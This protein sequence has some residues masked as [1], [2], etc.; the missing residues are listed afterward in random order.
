MKTK[1]FNKLPSFWGRFFA[2]AVVALVATKAIYFYFMEAIEDCFISFFGMFSLAVPQIHISWPGDNQMA[3]LIGIVF[4]LVAIEFAYKDYSK[5]HNGVWKGAKP[6]RNNVYGSARLLTKPSD[7][8]RAFKTWKKGTKPDPGIVVG[9]IG[10]S[11]NKLLINSARHHNLV[12]G[13]TGSGKSTSV[14]LPSLIQL[15]DS[16]SNFVALDPKGE[17]YA[18]TGKHAVEH[19]ANVIVIDFSDPQTSDGWLPLQP[20]ID[21]AQG[22]NGRRKEELPGEIRIL[23]DTLIPE[24][25]ENSPIWTQAS[26]ILFSGLCAFVIESDSIPDE[27]KNLST[28]AALAFMPQEKLQE[29]VENLD[30]NSSAYLSLSSIAYAP[31]ETYGGFAVNLSTALSVYSDSFVSPLLAR[32][33]FQVEDFLNKQTCLYIRFN[34]ST[35]AFNPLIAAFVEQMIDA[36]RRMA[37]NRCGG[38]LSRSVY[39]ILEELPQLPKIS[40]GKTL[41]ICRSQGIYVTVCIQSRSMLEAVYKRDSAGIFNNLST[42]IILQSED[43]DTNKYYSELFGNYTV[44][45]V[46]QSQTSSN[47]SGSNTKSYSFHKAQLFP[48]DDLAEWGYETGHLVMKNGRLY[49]CSSLP[50]SKTFVGDMLGLHGVE[51]GDLNLGDIAP[52]RPV[53]NPDPAPSKSWSDLDFASESRAIAQ[54]I[55]SM[56]VDP[57]YC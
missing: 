8:K 50:I 47:N 32:S 48:P 42:T 49:A 6:S 26:R 28:V 25:S 22:L 23:A 7:L 37:E 46:S 31:A 16:D 56:N 39:F 54:A 17:L 13:G 55:D 14:L 9:G 41:A 29:I 40:L 51:P 36:L 24:R 53:K 2:Y 27:C 11:K 34:S 35:E 52:L 30:E 21:C 33:D 12:L 57:R 4:L 10:S 20:A 3:L 5:F 15:I 45:V 1:S 38:K 43:L 19:G 44:E 18:V